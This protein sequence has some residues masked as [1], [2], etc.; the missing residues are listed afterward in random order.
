VRHVSAY[1]A[2]VV[3]VRNQAK[4]AIDSFEPHFF[5]NMVLALD[6]YFL[7]RARALEKKD[8]NPLNEVRIL[9][10]SMTNNNK[11][12]ADKTIKFDPAKFVLKYRIGDKIKL[13][14]A[15]FV[16]LSSAFFAEIERKYL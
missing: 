13:K 4:A 8:G 7:H 1:Q 6:S 9:C 10:N 5:N 15:D 11:M 2:L 12:C 3:A 16:R 14:E